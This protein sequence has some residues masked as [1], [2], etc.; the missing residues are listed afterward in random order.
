MSGGGGGGGGTCFQV[1]MEEK[2]LQEAGDLSC[3]KGRK[4][5]FESDCVIEKF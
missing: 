3:F 4:D 5:P 1:R 2:S